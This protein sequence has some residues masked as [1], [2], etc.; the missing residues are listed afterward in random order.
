MDLTEI[1]SDTMTEPKY[2][3]A[4]GEVEPLL[5]DLNR[6]LF[7]KIYIK[8]IFFQGCLICDEG[9][10]FHSLTINLIV[11]NDLSAVNFT[12]NLVLINYIGDIYVCMMFCKNKM[13]SNQSI[14][15]NIKSVI[16]L[17]KAKI[18]GGEDDC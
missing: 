6:T 14:S 7:K 18:T 13:F 12:R 9:R 11:Q 2:I 5:L 3:W 1:W 15:G 16:Y 17:W 4:W 10:L 8:H